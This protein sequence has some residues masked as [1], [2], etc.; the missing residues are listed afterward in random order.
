M[1]TQHCSA[2][3]GNEAIAYCFKDNVP[4]CVEC[5]NLHN[6]HKNAS[7]EKF[8]SAQNSY[9]QATLIQETSTMLAK[10][11]IV[12]GSLFNAAE[13]YLSKQKET[14]MGSLPEILKQTAFKNLKNGKELGNQLIEE[15]EKVLMIV[16]KFTEANINAIMHAAW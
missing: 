1:D 15:V 4:Y 5:F 11:K 10:H 13:Q 6:E 16:D 14:I 9:G 2:H 12:E 7:I 3:P 8:K